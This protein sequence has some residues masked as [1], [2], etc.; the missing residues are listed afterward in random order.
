M[1]TNNRM[2]EKSKS[3]IK[4]A[5][6]E[7]MYEKDFKQITV[8][9]LLKRANVSRGTFYA[10]FSN[11]E[12]VRQQL[13]NDLFDHADFLCGDYTASEMEAD[14]YP[15]ML[16][17]AEMMVASRD[18][19]KRL[20][21]FVNVYDLGINLKTWLTKYILSDE[22]LVERWGGVD[23]ATV[24][25]RFISGGVMHAYNMW[26]LEDFKVPAETFARTLCNILMNGLKLL[27]PKPEAEQEQ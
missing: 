13:I 3:A 2:V 15:V 27:A 21:K 4:N 10:H 9:E 16:M 25:A 22:A 1:S 12:D 20:F 26:I 17:A 6:L 18:P 5:L 24:Y 23:I 7:I 14:P 11:L 19:A 8:N